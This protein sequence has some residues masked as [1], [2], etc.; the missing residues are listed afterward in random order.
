MNTI[1]EMAGFLVGYAVGLLVLGLVIIAL[2]IL[3][4]EIRYGKRDK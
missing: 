3:W 4:D 1:Q 2:R